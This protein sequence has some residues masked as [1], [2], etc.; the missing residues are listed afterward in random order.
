MLRGRPIL[1]LACTVSSI[2]NLEIVISLSLTR[3]SIFIIIGGMANVLVF[4]AFLLPTLEYV[5]PSQAVNTK[6]VL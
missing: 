5:T 2:T 3:L 1:T 4:K 6:L